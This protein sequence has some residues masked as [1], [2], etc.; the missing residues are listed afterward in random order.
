M[1]SK[2]RKPVRKSR[3]LAVVRNDGRGTLLAV[4]VPDLLG[5]GLNQYPSVLTNQFWRP[6]TKEGFKPLKPK[7]SVGYMNHIGS[8]A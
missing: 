7:Y 1:E 2:Q 3:R 5:A 4:P 8:G 6:N